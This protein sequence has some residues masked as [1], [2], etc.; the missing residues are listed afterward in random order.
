MRNV[1]AWSTPLFGAHPFLTQT[2]TELIRLIGE[3]AANSLRREGKYRVDGT[4]PKETRP[5]AVV[6]LFLSK[7]SLWQTEQIFTAD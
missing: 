1:S 5:S 2:N 3:L 4:K 7:R 6:K